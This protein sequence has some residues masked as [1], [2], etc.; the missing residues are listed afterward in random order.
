[1]PVDLE[2]SD[3]D[4]VEGTDY[5]HEEYGCVRLLET[6][7]GGVIFR[8]LEANPDDLLHVVEETEEEFRTMA[9]P[10]PQEI[11]ADTASMNA[12]VNDPGDA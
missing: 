11:R 5:E 1:M 6:G 12:E 2:S 4:L 7:R 10:A 9:T 3:I 8:R